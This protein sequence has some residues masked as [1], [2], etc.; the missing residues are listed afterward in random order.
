M[1]SFN[2]TQQSKVQLI[3]I[4]K[5]IFKNYKQFCNGWSTRAQSVEVCDSRAPI[6]AADGLHA[7]GLADAA[8]NLPATQL[9]GIW[10]NRAWNIQ[11]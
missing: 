10:E 3:K 4:E 6:I 2:V 1:T 9:A 8:R 5:N 7:K 11:Q